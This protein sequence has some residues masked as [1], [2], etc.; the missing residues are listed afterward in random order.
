[1]DR[2]AI[3]DYIRTHRFQT[4]VGDIGMHG[5]MVD[6]FYTVGQWRDGYFTAVNS[7]GFAGLPQIELKAGWK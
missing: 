2:A 5:N 4:L 1:M 3:A 6:K 7:V